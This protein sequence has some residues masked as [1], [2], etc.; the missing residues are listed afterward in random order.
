MTISGNTVLGMGPTSGAAENSVQIA[1][2]ATG[3]VTS[4]TVGD[5]VWAP[6]QFGDTGDAAAGILIY[7]GAGVPVTGNTVNSTQYGIVVEGD[8]NGDA[9]GATISTNKVGARIFTTR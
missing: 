5:D 2:G 1:F 8:G 9:D 6:D 7:A 3:S 4:N